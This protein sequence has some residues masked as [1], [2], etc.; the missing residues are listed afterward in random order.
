[1]SSVYQKE[2][3]LDKGDHL[4][5]APIPRVSSVPPPDPHPIPCPILYALK[6]NSKRLFPEVTE[7]VQVHPFN[8]LLK[9]LFSPSCTGKHPLD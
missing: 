3:D 4:E 5:A 1:M 6:T 8:L 7:V 2:E 9:S